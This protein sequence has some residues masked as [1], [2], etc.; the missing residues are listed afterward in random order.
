M[1]YNT[2]PLRYYL[3]FSAVNTPDNL[4]HRRLQKTP[5]SNPPGIFVSIKP[6]QYNLM[7]L[8][9]ANIRYLE[10]VKYPEHHYSSSDTEY[11]H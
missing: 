8:K 10:F 3:K 4:S 7:S 11:C 5:N 1:D 9:S 2:S 6:M